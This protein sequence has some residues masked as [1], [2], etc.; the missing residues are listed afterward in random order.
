MFKLTKILN[1]G[2]N[3]SE[4]V[5]VKAAEATDYQIGAMALI[6]DGALKNA[7][8]SDTP[9]LIIGQSV[10]ADSTDTVLCHP[11]SPDMVFECRAYGEVASLAVGDRLALSVIDGAATGVNASASGAATVYELAGAN[12][13]GDVIFV[14]FI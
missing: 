2:V 10:K 7:S 8:A 4:P 13:N 6:E 3:V 12:K 11:V 14:R 5:R 9:T 1:S